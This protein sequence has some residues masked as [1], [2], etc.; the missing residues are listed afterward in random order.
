MNSICYGTRNVL[1]LLSPDNMQEFAEHTINTLLEIVAIQGTRWSGSGLIKRN[2][3]SLYNRGSNETG[4]TG[5]GFIVIK[6]AVKYI[7]GSETIQ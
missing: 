7:V 3:Y 1:T 2:N 4:Q 6:K 5:S